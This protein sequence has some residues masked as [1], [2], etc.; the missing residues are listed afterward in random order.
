[1]TTTEP[2]EIH[3]TIEDV[4]VLADGTGNIPDA[5]A[6]RLRPLICCAD[7]EHVRSTWHGLAIRLR[8]LRQLAADAGVDLLADGLW[9]Y[10]CLERLR[11][12]LWLSPADV[13]DPR[14][15]VPFPELISMARAFAQRTDGDEQAELLHLADRL[16]LAREGR[17]RIEPREVP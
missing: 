9:V 11:S 7:F 8:R 1:M 12:D 10:R 13:L 2:D 5:T 16:A 3:L 4:A 6:V 14:L 17:R 15:E